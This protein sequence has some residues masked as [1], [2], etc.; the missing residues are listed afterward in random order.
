MH[1]TPSK[2]YQQLRPEENM[3]IASLPHQHYTLMQIAQL[4]KSSA[5]SIS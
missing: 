2:L 4:L 3:T 1:H 5:S